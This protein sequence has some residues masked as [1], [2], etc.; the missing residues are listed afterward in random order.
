LW[1]REGDVVRS[2]TVLIGLLAVTAVALLVSLAA[3]PVIAQVRASLVVD[4][5]Q[6]ARQAVTIRKGSSFSTYDPI[7]TV[8]AG[9]RLVLEQIN[10]S[11][12][13]SDSYFGLF[14][15]PLSFANLI[16]SLP[17]KSYSG[18]VHIFDAQTRL[19]F[20]PGADLRL[21]MWIYGDAICTMSGYLVD[22]TP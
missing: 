5:D 9:K 22:V 2:R 17:E 12:F 7:Y 15:G 20:E 16:Y 6:P 21:K 19:Y 8:P 18:G 14:E 4:A 11:T 13:G 10:C 1:K 3:P